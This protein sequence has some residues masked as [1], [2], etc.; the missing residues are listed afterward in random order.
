MVN[1]REKAG[2]AEKEESLKH[3]TGSINHE[4]K[5]EN[6]SILSD[7]LITKSCTDR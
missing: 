1:P 5:P 4:V 7:F 2:N 6:I 3:K